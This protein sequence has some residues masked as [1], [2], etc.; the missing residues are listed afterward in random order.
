MKC[1]FTKEEKA[2]KDIFKGVIIKVV[3]VI[4]MIALIGA[5]GMFLYRHIT[6]NV[7]GLN[8]HE[9]TNSI[10]VIKEKLKETS[11]LNTGSYLCT[12][13]VTKA[14]SRKIKGWKIPLTQK[15]FTVS[16]DGTV[17]AGI[18]DLAKAKVTQHEKNVVVKLPE[19]EITSTEIDNNSFKMLD[20]SNNIFN[21]ISVEDLNDAQKELKKEMEKRAI[22]KG[23][24]DLAKSNA[25]ALIAEMLKSPIGAYDVKI[26][27]Q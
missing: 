7:L 2:M 18:K 6:N 19:V 13:V 9:K 25:E 12:T 21:P 26:E 14:D 17:K 11:E 27:W 24:L 1:L 3:S 22:E 8:Q 15:S 23:V 10:E 4:L 16:Y 20:E 5:G